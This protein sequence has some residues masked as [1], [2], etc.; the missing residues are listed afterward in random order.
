[1]DYLL[2]KNLKLGQNLFIKL[3]I[4]YIVLSFYN[5]IWWKL[6]NHEDINDID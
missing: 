6:E 4:I 5:N 1:M 3:I 2:V